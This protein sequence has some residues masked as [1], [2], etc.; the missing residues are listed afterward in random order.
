M[1]TSEHSTY[2]RHVSMLI[3]TPFNLCSVLAGELL[4][5]QLLL[6]VKGL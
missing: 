6:I 1:L 3:T 5:L 2:H 4:T